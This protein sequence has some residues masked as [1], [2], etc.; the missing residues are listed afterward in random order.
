MNAGKCLTA[1]FIITALGATTG[2]QTLERRHQIELRIGMWNQTTDVRSTVGIDGVQSTVDN[3][4]FVGGIAYGYWLRENVALQIAADV[5]AAK[6]ESDVTTLGTVSSETAAVSAVTLGIKYYVPRPVAGSTVRPFLRGA[7]GPYMGSQSRTEVG[8]TVVT[9]SRKEAAFGGQASA[10]VDF[11]LSHRFML[12]V[13]VGYNQ[14]SD[15]DKPIGGSVNFSGPVAGFG[16][17]VL[18][19]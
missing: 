7:V 18:L 11:L 6:V 2:A 4:G 17:S 10:G 5:M 9:E 13:T 8:L 19:G 12:G 16:F 3:N 15:F 14:M 1:L